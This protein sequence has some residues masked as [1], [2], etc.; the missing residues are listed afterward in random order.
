MQAKRARPLSRQEIL[1]LAVT[2]ADAFTT[3]RYLRHREQVPAIPELEERGKTQLPGIEGSLLDLYHAFWNPEPGMREE[4]SP[5]RRYWKEL[6]RQT[7]KSSAYEELHASTQLKELQSV[8]GT[9]AM[10]ES[11]IAMVPKEDQEKLQ[12]LAARQAEAN[13]MG[14][15]AQQ[16]Q[17]NAQASQQLA[18]AAAFASAPQGVMADKQAS[19]SG[20]GQPQ[21]GQR[22]PSGQP[23]T[24]AGQMTPEQAKAIANELAQAAAKAQA[25]AQAARELTQEAKAK[26]EALAQELMGKAGSAEAQQKLD[27]LRRMGLAA[28]KAAQAKVEEVSDT[29][30]AWGLEEGELFRQSIPEALGL[31]ER[32]RKNE[33]FRKF[34]EMLGRIRKIAARKAKQKIAG[35]G[36]RVTTVETGRDLKRAQTSELI[37]LTHPALRHKALVRWARG[38]LRLYGQKAKQKLGHGP[39]VVCEDASGSM[40]GEKQKWCKATVLAL[41][42]YAKLQKRSF[43]WV[44]FDASVKKTG[45]YAQGQMTPEQMLELAESRAGGGTNFEKPLRAALEMIQKQ[46]LKKADVC[47][48]TDGECAVSDAFLREFRAAKKALEFNVVTVLCDVGSSADA[49]VREFS[50]R[51]EHISAF[52]AEKAETQ[53]FRHL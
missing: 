32:M 11:V 43:G 19:Q 25:E 49:T 31:L 8:L 50:D 7:L 42:H 23:A 12:E 18:E 5:D 30:E 52:T 13:E 22:S 33:H 44:M 10:G 1:S 46:G 38:E 45:V 47:F 21:P 29:I 51:I 14:E 20:S 2:D 27:E 40:D 48:I 36:A 39:V 9:I 53:L 35:E 16:A 17:A 34:A 37:A 26:A 3:L 15:Q 28:V 41:A 24:S 6:L 4:V